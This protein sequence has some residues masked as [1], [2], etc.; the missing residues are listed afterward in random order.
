MITVE[1]IN[2]GDAAEICAFNARLRAAGIEFQS[3]SRL[4]ELTTP[5]SPGPPLWAQVWVA[6]DEETV[7]GGFILKHERLFLA[8]STVD[9]GNFQLPLS[10][11]IVDRRYATV[12]FDLVRTALRENSRLYSLG[13]GG[14]HRPLPRLL[15][16]LGWTVESVPF[17]FRVI[18]GG[19]FT[20]NIRALRTS[21]LRQALFD[22]AALT[23]IA[24]AVTACWRVAARATGKASRRS[25]SLTPVPEFDER[26]N[27]VFH[28]CKPSFG[29]MLDRRSESLNLKF[30]RSDARLARFLIEKEGRCI[31]WLIVTVT[32]LHDHR[33]F[34]SMC[35]GA[36][37][38]GLMPLE[39]TDPAIALL[40]DI[41]IR[42]GVDTIVSN[43]SHSAWC[44]AL[45]RNLFLPG[46]SNFVLARSPEFA[47]GVLLSDLHV[48]RGDGDGPINL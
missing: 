31:G 32:R 2:E 47:T 46:S 14:T 22:A 34:G 33:Q 13:M 45:R 36:I 12:A 4:A 20:R 15:G 8:D 21:K 16:R 44:R 27:A 25:M 10:E 39:F 9:V 30:P 28:A 48:N 43:Q 3:P 11:G 7:R 41:M 5:V 40:S 29:G 24:G 23:G 37:V 18:R 6:R 38:D 1:Q 19:A 26:V 42:M 17:F 35:L